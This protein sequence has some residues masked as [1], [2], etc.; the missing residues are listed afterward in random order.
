[1]LRVPIVLAVVASGGL[2]ASSASAARP[3]T[4]PERAA[5]LSSVRFWMPKAPNES[6]TTV[7]V[8]CISTVAPGYAAAAFRGGVLGYPRGPVLLLQKVNAPQPRP[9]RPYNIGLWQK[10]WFNPRRPQLE[11]PRQQAVRLRAERDLRAQC[12]FQH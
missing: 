12:F 10:V 5:I 11:K 6:P 3:A 4:P 1:M 2:V 8:A 7:A 9:W